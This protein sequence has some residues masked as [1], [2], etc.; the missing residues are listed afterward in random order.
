MTISRRTI[1]RLLAGAPLAAAALL[2]GGSLLRAS[3]EAPAATGPEAQATPPEPEETPLGRFLAKEEADLTSEEKR[4]VR[5]QVSGLEQ[6][7]NEVRAFVL[8][9]EVP[10][11][12]TF[13]AERPARGRR[14][15]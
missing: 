10:P 13:R 11:A 6:S 15:R 14:S 4:K 8:E 7:L 12:G 3:A 1:T 5:K 9:N 2:P